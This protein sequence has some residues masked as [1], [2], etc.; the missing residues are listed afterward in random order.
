MVFPDC[1]NRIPV[2]R[3]FALISAIP[4]HRH[5]SSALLVRITRRECI[6]VAVFFRSLKL[7]IVNMYHFR[8][9][10]ATVLCVMSIP[11]FAQK[12]SIAPMR[13]LQGVEVTAQRP[14]SFTLK[15]PMPVTI[16]SRHTIEMMGSRRLDEITGVRLR[17]EN[18]TFY[19]VN[20]KSYQADNVV[21]IQVYD[22][23]AAGVYN[24]IEL[25]SKALSEPFVQELPSGQEITV[26]LGCGT[27][28]AD[29]L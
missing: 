26:Q 9:L 19:P 4:S 28:L 3:Y 1:V 2:S 20:I 18:G 6:V 8:L 14:V 17:G 15:V 23:L 10:H 22:N 13:D 29:L 12:D 25:T 5:Y 7:V 27:C 16:I 21:E 11:V 24:A